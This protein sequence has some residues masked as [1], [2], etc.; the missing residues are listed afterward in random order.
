[1]D[2]AVEDVHFIRELWKREYPHWK[3]RQGNPPFAE[4]IAAEFRGVDYNT[5]VERVRAGKNFRRKSPR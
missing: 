1:L 5:L 4:E 3:R 2:E